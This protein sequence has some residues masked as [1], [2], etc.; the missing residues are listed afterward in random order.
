MLGLGVKKK[1][2]NNVL[3]KSRQAAIFVK[4][5]HTSLLMTALGHMHV[6]RQ[7]ERQSQSLLHLVL[8]LTGKP[9]VQKLLL[10]VE[11]L[12]MPAAL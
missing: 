7:R 10:Q 2:D 4:P 11:S 8:F 12:S 6:K 5:S 3:S 9:S 1:N